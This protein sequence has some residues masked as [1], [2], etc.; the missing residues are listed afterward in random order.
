MKHRHPTVPAGTITHEGQSYPIIDGIVD[1]PP[2]LGRHLGLAVLPEPAIEPSR[3]GVKS[4]KD[5]KKK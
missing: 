2:D 3:D 1:C 5:A 4:A